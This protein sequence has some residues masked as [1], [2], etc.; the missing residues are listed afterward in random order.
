MVWMVRRVINQRYAR[1]TLGEKRAHR[2]VCV[3]QTALEDT[4][5]R[6]TPALTALSLLLFSPPASLSLLVQSSAL[7]VGSC[8]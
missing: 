8:T 4:G 2:C 3:L 7:L 6:R 1:L 5:L